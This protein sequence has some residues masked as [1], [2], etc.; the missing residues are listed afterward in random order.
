MYWSCP[1]Y[2]LPSCP[3]LSS[4][5]LFLIVPPLL[6]DHCYIFFLS[7]HIRKNMW[8]L[9]FCIWLMYS[10]SMMISSSIHFPTNDKISFFLWVNNNP[11][12][13]S[14]TFYLLHSSVNRHLGWFYILVFVKHATINIVMQ[15]SL[16]YDDFITFRYIPRSDAV[17]FLF[18]E[19]LPYCFP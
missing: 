6:S 19:E 3:L 16:L 15:V 2:L 14:I 7:F 10:V 1:S 4:P 9:S 8:Y 18:F 5:F 11:M 12:C 13:V 17:L